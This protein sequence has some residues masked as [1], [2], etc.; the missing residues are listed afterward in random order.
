[1]PLPFRDDKGSICYP[2]NFEGW[3]WKPEMISAI[4]GWPDL[5]EI[6]DAYVYHTICDHKPF[7]HIPSVYRR[8]IEWGKEGAGKALKLGLNAGYGKNAQSVGDNP[9]Y[10]QWVW[11]GMTTA[12][13]RAQINEGITLAKDPWNVL[14]IATDGIYACEDLN[15]PAPRDTGT[16]EVTVL[17]GDEKGQVKHKPLGGWETKAVPEGAFFAKPGLYFKLDPKLSD[18]RA[19][20]VGRKEVY[21]QKQALIEGFRNWDRQDFEEYS[22]PL[23]GRRFFGAKHSIMA[24]STCS[25]C[26]KIWPGVPEQKCPVCGSIGDAI[27][28]R[29]VKA[30][31]GLPA[32]GRWC[33]RISNIRFDPRP[34]RE[35]VFGGDKDHGRLLI[36]DAGGLTSKPYDVGQTTPEGMAMREGKEF[37]L[38][39]PDWV[40]GLG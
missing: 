25:K 29:R 12:T 39:Q 18:I 8:R 19:R 21:E 28:T 20:G 2:T 16:A 23:T 11:A 40:E 9:P 3:A 35:L 7:E 27:M 15:M 13:T 26:K 30:P 14:S 38:E 34:K 6:T 1:M 37:M 33:E 17:E 32:Y 4:H 22:V 36:R 31:D 10:Q 24:F 5:V